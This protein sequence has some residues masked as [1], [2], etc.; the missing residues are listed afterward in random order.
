MYAEFKRKNKS[1]KF[2]IS[3]KK[4]KLV[5][6]SFSTVP[7]ERFFFFEVFATPLLEH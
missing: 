2:S 5:A 3:T 7:L 1:K 4:T 6:T